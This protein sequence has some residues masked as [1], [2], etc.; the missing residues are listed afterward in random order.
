MCRVSVKSETL[1]LKMGSGRILEL[2]TDSD[3]M[4]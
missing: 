1:Y 4:V 3:L 2:L